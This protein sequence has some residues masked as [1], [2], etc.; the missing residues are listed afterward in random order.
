M[1]KKTK[2]R[3]A[4]WIEDAR[5]SRLMAAAQ[6]GDRRSYGQLLRE[7]IPVLRRAIRRLWPM[8]QNSEIDD[9]VQETLKSLHA[10]RNTYDKSRPFLPWLLGIARY[11]LLDEQRKYMRS[12]KREVALDDRDETLFAIDTNTDYSETDADNLKEAISQLPPRQ[13]TAMELLKLKEMS[14]KEAS[15]VSGMSVTA[16]K[17]ATHRAMKSLRTILGGSH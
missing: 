6:G 16:L 11:R 13:R 9:I 8:A 5:W 7:I 4:A 1:E 12:S 10:V 17:I 2:L 3:S 15:Q 14:L